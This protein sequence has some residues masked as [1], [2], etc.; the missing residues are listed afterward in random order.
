MNIFKK[1]LI[2]LS[3]T[4]DLKMCK[5]LV[6]IGLFA[7][8]KQ[9]IKNLTFKNNSIEFFDKGKNIDF[10]IKKSNFFI[11]T[12]GTSLFET[13]YLNTPSIM[14]KFAQHEI[15]AYKELF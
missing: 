8:N 9:V 7:K 13:S 5:F 2:K 12:A 10:I 6:I 11:G 1:I 3:K 4:Q 15:K 14:F